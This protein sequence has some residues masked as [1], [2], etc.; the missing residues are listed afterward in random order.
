MVAERGSGGGEE[1]VARRGLLHT[2]NTGTFVRTKP[3]KQVNVPF[4]GKILGREWFALRIFLNDWVAKKTKT[5]L[6]RL[7]S[8]TS[9]SIK[10]IFSNNHLFSD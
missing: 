8:L 6:V 1:C 9:G 10:D 5:E 7:L 2:L 3:L 4:S